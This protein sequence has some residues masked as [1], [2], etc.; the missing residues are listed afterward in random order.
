MCKQH[1]HSITT[2]SEQA[3]KHQPVVHQQHLDLLHV[4]HNELVEAVGK[5]I[6]GLLVGT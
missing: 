5:D 1:E 4:V 2:E 3:K 6:S